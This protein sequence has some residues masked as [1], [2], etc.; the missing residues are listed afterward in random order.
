[1]HLR[2]LSITLLCLRFKTYLYYYVEMTACW[3]LL[4][5]CVLRTIMLIVF[6]RKINY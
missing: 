2:E 1:M 4:V 6:Q 5:V 3:I